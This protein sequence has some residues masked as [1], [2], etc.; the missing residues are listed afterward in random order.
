MV[1]EAWGEHTGGRPAFIMISG[2]AKANPGGLNH[3]NWTTRAKEN[4][5]AMCFSE[6]HYYGEGK[7]TD[8]TVENIEYLSSRQEL[9]DL[10][11]VIISE[12][13]TQSD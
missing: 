8:M 7:Q 2:M 5:A 10:G 3:G 6:Q 9:K 1:P 11:H 4:G 12:L 13:C